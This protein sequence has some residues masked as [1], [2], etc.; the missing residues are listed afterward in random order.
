MFLELMSTVP[1][2]S[3]EGV[4]VVEACERMF[5]A[6]DSNQDQSIDIK[7]VTFSSFVY[8]TIFLVTF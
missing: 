3:T 8:L 1:L 4:S 5:D 2:T 6:F 7:E